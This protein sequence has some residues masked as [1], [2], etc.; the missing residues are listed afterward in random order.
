[1]CMKVTEELR[2]LLRNIYT[3]LECRSVCL[4]SDSEQHDW[5][6][7]GGA[8]TRPHKCLNDVDNM[9]EESSLS[10]RGDAFNDLI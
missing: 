10:T 5:T 7:A 3:Q 2:R 9:G 8:E 6:S 1:M 4:S